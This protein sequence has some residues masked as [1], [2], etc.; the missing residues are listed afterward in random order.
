[1]TIQDFNP[2]N[3]T[4][5]F[6]F[7]ADDCSLCNGKQCP[8]ESL[9]DVRTCSDTDMHINDGEESDSCMHFATEF[10]KY[11]RLDFSPIIIK[12]NSCNH[13]TFIDGQH[14]T[15][16]YSRLLRKGWNVRMDIEKIEDDNLCSICTEFKNRTHDNTP[17]LEV[18][19]IAK[20]EL[21]EKILH[22]NEM[23]EITF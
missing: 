21:W 8:V 3:K 10:I 16:V 14:R 2:L 1:M 18:S 23:V 11:G 13:Y 5:L 20:T 12:H 4:F 15:C 22:D 19:E 6:R 7:S 17:G 9:L